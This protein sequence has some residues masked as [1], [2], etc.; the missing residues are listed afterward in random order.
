MKKNKKD[1]LY[2]V[3]TEPEGNGLHWAGK[4]VIVSF[5]CICSAFMLMFFRLSS[6]ASDDTLQAAASKQSTRTLTFNKTRGQIYD[7]KLNSF[8]DTLQST[9][10]ACPGNE[11][12]PSPFLTDEE[13]MKAGVKNTRELIIPKRLPT[14]QLAPHII[15]YTDK[16]GN[17]VTGLEKAYDTLLNEGSGSST[18]SFAVDSH[19]RALQGIAPSLRYSPALSQGVVTTI[20]SRIQ[21]LCERIGDKYI[22]KGAIVVMEPQTGKLRA[23]ASFPTYQLSEL[24]KSINDTEN[25]PLINR[26][27]CGYT[28]GST[29]KIATASAAL[30]QGI[31]P[32]TEFTCL[33][34]VNVSGQKFGCHLKTGHGTLALKEAMALSCN[35][36]FIELGLMLEKESFYNMARDLSFGKPIKL[37]PGVTA[38]GGILPMVNQLKNPADIGNLAFGQGLLT[39]TPLQVAQMTSAIIN[40]GKTPQA[41]LIEGFT[42]NGSLIDKRADVTP[43]I[44]ALNPAIAEQIKQYLIYSVMETPSQKSKPQYVT[45]GGKTGTAQTGQLKPDGTELLHGWFS[46]FFPAENPK[47]VVTIVSEDAKSGNSNASPVFAELADALYQPVYY[48]GDIK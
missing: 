46:G 4:R 14:R 27:L 45:A 19:G 22:K 28:V 25:S 36:Y 30:T 48:S 34:E 24:E 37:A 9:V 15:G 5:C 17:G 18:I 11:K 33:G 16:A 40:G 31:S 42:Q 2:E 20:D 6:L 29:F 10:F 35:P 26:A 1:Q 13:K 43:P 7:C 32:Q 21:E 41:Q 12:N 38:T 23:V 8:T 3:E 39:A 47:Y 44:I